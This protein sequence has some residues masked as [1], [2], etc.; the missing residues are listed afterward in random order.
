MSSLFRNPFHG[1]AQKKFCSGQ[2]STNKSNK[3]AQLLHS[4]K[5]KKSKLG[6]ETKVKE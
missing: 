3:F 6:V 1:F 4:P 2:M 5:Y